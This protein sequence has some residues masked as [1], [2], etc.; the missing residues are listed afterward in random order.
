MLMFFWDRLPTK[1]Q[2]MQNET[3]AEVPKVPVSPVA[4]W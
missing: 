1:L 2:L 3:S 4:S